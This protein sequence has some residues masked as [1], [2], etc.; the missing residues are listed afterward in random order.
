MTYGEL[1]QKIKQTLADAGCE[2]PGFDAEC[3]LED[4]GGLPHRQR[5][6][7]LNEDVPAEIQEAVETATAYRASG[8]PLQYILGNWEFL[9]L[10]LHVGEGVLIPRPE[11][12]LLCEVGANFL[13]DHW[14]HYLRSPQ[15]WDLCAGSGCVSLGLCKLYP[16]ARVTAVELSDFALYYLRHNCVDYS[17]FNVRVLQADVLQD[18]PSLRGRADLILSNP[19]YIPTGELEGLMTE[20]HHEPRMALDGDVDGLKF[21]RCF[22]DKWVK[23]LADGGMLAV[24]VGAGQAPAVAELFRD[25]GLTELQIT[26]DG[27]GIDRVVSGIWHANEK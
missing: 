6:R 20:V 18:V 9:S 19:P 17:Q 15:V 21:Y 26:T 13:K 12:E 8:R 16:R 2:F 14:D 11:T 25:A 4:I 5:A 1:F 27:S 24:E 7:Y 10:T 22:A 23:R 3:I